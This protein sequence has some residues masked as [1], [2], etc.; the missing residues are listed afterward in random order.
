MLKWKHKI[1][2]PYSEVLW[3]SNLA[4]HNTSTMAILTFIVIKLF[5]VFICIWIFIAGFK[6]LENNSILGYITLFLDSV[7]I[8]LGFFIYSTLDFKKIILTQNG[9]IL[10]TRFS[11]D[12]FCP[13]GEFII[14]D[15]SYFRIPQEVIG[16]D[17]KDIKK[18]FIIPKSRYQIG[19]IL[20]DIESFSDICQQY[21]QKALA[22]MNLESKTKLFLK[23]YEHIRLLPD[24]QEY[25][26][27]IFTIDFS[28]YIKEMQKY[29]Q[30]NKD[31]NE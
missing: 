11:G 23:Y 13:Y 2:I 24:N 26:R 30:T 28:P 6:L 10:K 12:I 31:K 5:I 14:Y 8:F 7:Y 18:Y 15:D 21:T 20:G 4:L 16:I 9:L 22:T 17:L 25:N 3:E 29:Y 1:H 19:D 27:N